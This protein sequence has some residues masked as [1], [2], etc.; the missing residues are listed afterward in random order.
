MAEAAWRAQSP[1]RKLSILEEVSASKRP[2]V[3]YRRHHS[4]HHKQQHAPTIEPALVDPN[5]VHKLF[6]DS[7][8]MVIEEEGLKQDVKDPLIESM[9]LEAFHGAVE[10]CMVETSRPHTMG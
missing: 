1:K 10:E 2:K 8:K 3:P 4:I 9:A 7:I 6:I 5:I